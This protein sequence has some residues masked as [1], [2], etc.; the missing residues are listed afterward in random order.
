VRVAASKRVRVVPAEVVSQIAN[1]RDV[2][3]ASPASSRDDALKATGLQE[4]SETTVSTECGGF[5][6]CARSDIAIWAERF[7]LGIG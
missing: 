2:A 7:T 6:R 1:G 3:P 4:E 5:P